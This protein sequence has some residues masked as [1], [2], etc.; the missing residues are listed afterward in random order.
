MIVRFHI[1]NFSRKKPLVSL[2]RFQHQ[3]GDAERYHLM[4]WGAVN[5]RQ[6]GSPRRIAG[7]CELSAIT[8]PDCFRTGEPP[9]SLYL[10]KDVRV[11]LFRPTNQEFGTVGI[12]PTTGHHSAPGFRQRK[13]L[14]RILQRSKH[15]KH[16]QSAP[17]TPLGTPAVLS[18]RGT[19]FGLRQLTPSELARHAFTIIRQFRPRV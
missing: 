13:P 15:G 2:I 5:G 16:G 12:P 17:V 1:F 4:S 6:T 10:K 9:G 18:R 3:A 14:F 11:A 8:Q 7:K 19:S